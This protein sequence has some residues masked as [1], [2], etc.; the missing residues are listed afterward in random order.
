M[1]VER[2]VV[3]MSCTEMGPLSLD[4]G[5]PYDQPV[6]DKIAELQQRERVKMGFDRAGSST[7]HPEDRDVDLTDKEQIRRSR[8]RDGFKTAA[9]KILAIECQNFAGIVV[10]ICIK[11]G[12]I[13]DVEHEEMASIIAEAESDAA[14]SVDEDG[15]LV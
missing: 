8:W 11:G 12:T 7:T 2:K 10:V 5:P 4:G 1:C 15:V 3:V 6:M 13:T 14:T 9:K